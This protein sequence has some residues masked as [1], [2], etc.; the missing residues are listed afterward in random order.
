[1]AAAKD[2]RRKVPMSPAAYTKPD[3]PVTVGHLLDYLG[4]ITVGRVQMNR[5]VI[6]V[7]SD[8]T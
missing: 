1:M 6:V 5:P 7:S 8:S 3:V 4:F 2:H